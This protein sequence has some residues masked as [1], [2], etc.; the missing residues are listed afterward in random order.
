MAS[1]ALRHKIL[2]HLSASGGDSWNGIVKK[3]SEEV[4]SQFF[5]EQ[6]LKQ[7]IDS[8]EVLRATMRGRVMYKARMEQ[9]PKKSGPYSYDPDKEPLTPKKGS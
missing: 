7:M 2:S 9:W 1:D 5:V 3:L 6:A 4:G 8:K